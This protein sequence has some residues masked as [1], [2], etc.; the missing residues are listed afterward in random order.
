MQRQDSTKIYNGHRVWRGPL[1]S[2]FIFLM[3]GPTLLNFS[4]KTNALTAVVFTLII[5]RRFFTIQNIL[6][7]NFTLS[8]ALAAKPNYSDNCVSRLTDEASDEQ[9]DLG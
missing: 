6:S 4:L 5:E 7:P 9:R 1:W 8:S 2:A 3:E